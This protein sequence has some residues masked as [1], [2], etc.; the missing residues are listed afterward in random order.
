MAVNIKGTFKKD[1]RP[2]NGLEAIREE[3][4][5]NPHRRIVVVAIVS[6]HT[7]KVDYKEGGYVT[8]T[9]SFDNIEPMM[10][11]ADAKDALELLGHAFEARTGNPMP[12]MSLFDGP[13]GDDTLEGQEEIPGV[14]GGDDADSAS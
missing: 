5:R 1:D 8:P 12:P 2:N 7:G 11:G 4:H 3:I 6:A 13:G 10:S 14:V 9:V